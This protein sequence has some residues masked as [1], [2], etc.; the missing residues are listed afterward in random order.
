MAKAI[1]VDLRERA[2]EALPQEL[3]TPSGP[4][5]RKPSNGSHQPTAQTTSKRQDTMQLDRKML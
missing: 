5:P 3:S 1:S 2:C 4:Q